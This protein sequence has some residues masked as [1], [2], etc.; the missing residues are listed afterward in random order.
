MKITF[1]L[2]RICAVFMLLVLCFGMSVKPTSATTNPNF[3]NLIVFVKFQED[4]RD[5]FNVSGNWEN[6]KEMYD[7]GDYSFYEYMK[8]ISRGKLIVNNYM[9]QENNSETGVVTF[10]LAGKETDYDENSD[11]II[12]HEVI[13]AIN[14][15]QIDV[16]FGANTPDNVD[17][18]ILDNL[19]IIVQGKT[20]DRESFMYPHMST[21]TDSANDVLKAD[22]INADKDIMVS[23]YNIV[24]SYTLIPFE[25]TA[26]H[27]GEEQGVLCHEFLHTLGLPDLYRYTGTGD[28][29]G[30]W[31]IMGATTSR[32]LQYPLSYSREQLGWI[33]IEE[34]SESGSYTLN[35]VTTP[36]GNVAYKLE[37]PM[38]SGE[39]FIVEYRK[40]SDDIF[41]FESKLQGTG[42][43]VYRVDTSVTD[44]S[45][46][47]G[48]NY[49]YVFRPEET[50]L[51]DG[52]NIYDAIIDPSMGET[53]YGSTDLSATADEDTIY[54]SDGT[55]SGIAF[56]NI[57]ISADGES[58]SFDVEFSDYDSLDLWRDVGSESAVGENVAGKGS[59]AVKDDNNIYV[60]YSLGDGSGVEVKKYDGTGW[61]NIG[62]IITGVNYPQ[63]EVLGNDVYLLCGDNQFKP[64]L[65]KLVSGSW[66]K[67]WSDTDY[68]NFLAF[69]KTDREL[70]AYYTLTNQTLVIRNVVTGQIVNTTLTAQY[71]SNP[72][73]TVMNGTFYVLY[74]DFLGADANAVLKKLESNGTWT[75]VKKCDISG[76]NIHTLSS[77]NNTLVAL[78]VNGSTGSNRY[79]TYDGTGVTE[80]TSLDWIDSS[81]LD[82]QMFFVDDVTYVSMVLS[83]SS[84]KAI[85]MMKT[86]NEWAQL[87]GDISISASNLVISNS[88]DNFYGAVTAMGSNNI[89]V[90]MHEIISEDSSGDTDVTP[91]DNTT[92]EPSV[93]PPDNTTE[94]PPVTPPDNT[95]E[96]PSVTPSV[97]NKQV[98][99][100]PPSGY[101]DTTLWVDGKAFSGTQSQGNLSVILDNTGAKTICMYKY[102]ANGIPVGM[103]VWTLKHNGTSYVVTPQPGL[104]NILSYH[105][106]SVRVAGQSGIRFKTGISAD[107]R[108]RLT[109][110][111]VNG[112]KLVEYGTVV[113]NKA[114][115]ST[116]P[117]IK[118]GTKTTFGRAYWKEGNKLNDL[119]FETVD[120]RHRFTS[121]LIGI[122]VKNYK[123]EF[124]FRG[125]ITLTCNG[126]NYTIY[127]PVV[128]RSIYGVSKQV[129]ASGQFSSSS[130]AYKFLKKIISDADG[131]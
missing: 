49:I 87:G 100:T 85:M 11:H 1:Y 60:A 71:F 93:T 129:I 74:S 109:T 79:I 8:E 117:L 73:V 39:F 46:A 118:G 106:F 82:T 124:A 7:E 97:N 112:F 16:D 102:N 62:G 64:T 125:Y 98:I 22:S 70:Y 104:E 17:S 32:W 61:T 128:S 68:T 28:P 84:G 3:C 123:T 37:S 121:V 21:Y 119:I 30:L 27:F 2:K 96:E 108:N 94:E 116:Y 23:N 78:A 15:G 101:T 24:N 47:A 31:S 90:K 114:Y 9:P 95:T 14:N 103:Y 55:N 5:A 113:M 83:G 42:L 25:D 65:Y 51:H 57:Q 107:L 111:G 34:I 40:K 88:K 66:V 54:Y 89:L 99:I 122:P 45:N 63:I 105:G 29:V 38:S 36:T 18:G 131:L 77:N 72:A 56:S 13:T 86:E 19:T 33:D 10:T 26:I 35:N 58:I 4:T 67:Q 126:E 80:V 53:A 92:E 41:G 59:I 76:T 12:I 120:G 81:I 110:S 20:T 69:V 44:K 115:M 91:P 48:A 43:L 75:T 130:A 50:N 6:I 127:G 52:A